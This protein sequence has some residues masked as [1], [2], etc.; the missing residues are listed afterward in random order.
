MQVATEE[1]NLNELHKLVNRE[2]GVK[3]L[4]VELPV[5]VQLSNDCK[6]VKITHGNLVLEG[7]V[8]RPLIH[9][10][11]GCAWGKNQEFKLIEKIWKERFSNNRTQ[12]EHE[13][14]AVFG[15][16]DLSIRYETDSQGRNHIYGIVKPYFFDVNQFEFRE[17][18]IEQARQSTSLTPESYGFKKGSFGEVVEY[19]KFNNPGFQTEFRYGLVYARNNGYEAYK[20]NWGRYILI[21][22]NGLTVWTGNNFR[23]KHTKEIDLAEFIAKTVEG[24]IGNQKFLEEKI[25][26]SRNSQININAIAELMNRL[27]LAQASKNRI[28][29]R[30]AIE[31]QQVGYNEW[32]LSQ[33]LTWLGSHEKAI[34]QKRKQELIVLGTDILEHSLREVLDG[35]SMLFSD[36]SYGLVLPKGL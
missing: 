15:C 26:T 36:A 32:A 20:V 16:N 21:C 12:L 6:T 19:F 11:G 1:K 2:A 4:D 31:S 25:S 24:G 30:L 29:D 34:P 7:E 28:T 10:I 3:Q 13:L 14:A 35:E 17:K 27:S 8:K 18:F 33:S 22:T 23:W 9:R 5:K